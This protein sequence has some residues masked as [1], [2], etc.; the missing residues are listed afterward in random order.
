MSDPNLAQQA[1]EFGT[2]AVIDTT[3]DNL[4]NPLMDGV[5][6]HLPG[7]E[8]IEQMLNTEVDQVINNEINTEVNKG[9][10]GMIQDAENLFNRE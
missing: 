3:V 8:G 4:V 2:D 9:V 10:G 6:S 7:G 1:G 5:L